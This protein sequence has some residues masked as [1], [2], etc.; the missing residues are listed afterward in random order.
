MQTTGTYGTPTGMATLTAA[1]RLQ[2]HLASVRKRENG[3]N[4]SKKR[5]YFQI[6]IETQQWGVCSRRPIA[7]L[8]VPRNTVFLNANSSSNLIAREKRGRDH[9]KGKRKWTIDEEETET[10]RDTKK[11]CSVQRSERGPRLIE[12][13]VKTDPC[14]CHCSIMRWL[15]STTDT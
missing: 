3:H 5:A 4:V 10:E 7:R 12:Q 15:T 9:K 11:V 8:H 14:T 6:K 1:S 2:Y 13:S